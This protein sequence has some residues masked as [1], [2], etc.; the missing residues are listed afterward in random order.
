MAE[1]LYGLAA[2]YAGLAGTERVYDLFC[3]IGTL[4]LTLALRAGEV[5]AVEISEEAVADA[6]RNAAAERDRERA[7]LRG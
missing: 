2:E 4:S 1:R 7:L 3:G 6:I 5:W